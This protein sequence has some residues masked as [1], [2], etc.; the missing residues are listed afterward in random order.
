MRRGSK[1]VTWDDEALWNA[2]TVKDQSISWSLYPE[3]G[4]QE[5]VTKRE[6][7]DMMKQASSKGTS[8]A[9]HSPRL[10]AT[11]SSSDSEYL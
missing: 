6:E 3:L 11:R 7:A 10:L 5:R 2:P 4:F 9:S 1:W 8:A